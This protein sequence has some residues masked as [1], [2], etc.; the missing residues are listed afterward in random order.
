MSQKGPPCTS[1]GS[2]SPKHPTE[3]SLTG[4]GSASML[5]SPK[6][7]AEPEQSGTSPAPA[8][9]NRK[10]SGLRHRSHLSPLIQSPE[11]SQPAPL[12][13]L[14]NK[15]KKGDLNG[16]AVSYEFTVAPI[17]TKQGRHQYLRGEDA[18]AWVE[19]RAPRLGMT[20][21]SIT[22]IRSEL[23]SFEHQD[24]K[25]SFPLLT[26]QGTA[27]VTDGDALAAALT[28]GVGKRRTYGAGMLKIAPLKEATRA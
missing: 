8:Q 27:T 14:I 16:V 1:P 23:V 12:N 3:P 10:N 18:I 21:H 19:E 25:I 7:S 11:L 6:P 5:P 26:V 17:R 24:S 4:H 9:E 20:L 13:T 2:L 22:V 15:A 28:Q